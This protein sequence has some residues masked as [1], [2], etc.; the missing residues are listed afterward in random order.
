MEGYRFV[1][2]RVICKCVKCK[3][4][5]N[6]NKTIYRFSNA[7]LSLCLCLSLLVSLSLSLSLSLSFSKKISEKL[8]PFMCRKF[9]QTFSKFVDS[10]NLGRWKQGLMSLISKNLFLSNTHASST[11]K[12]VTKRYDGWWWEFLKCNHV[13]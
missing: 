2:C 3:P 1:Y 11:S 13:A 10:K 7:G 5:F 12:L 6:E 8:I 9:N 4:W